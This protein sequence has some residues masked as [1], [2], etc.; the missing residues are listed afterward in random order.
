VERLVQ[1][2]LADLVVHRQYL[3]PD[4]SDMNSSESS[5]FA[6]FPNSTPGKQLLHR[7]KCSDC[8]FLL[9]EATGSFTHSTIG[10]RVH[11]EIF[12]LTRIREGKNKNG[13]WEYVVKPVIRR[14]GKSDLFKLN[15]L[16]LLT[17]AIGEFV[18]KYVAVS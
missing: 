9:F 8:T 18:E 11:R 14:W 12:P 5:S 7:V 13:E 3:D 16:A 1:I 6:S 2:E 17:T 10:S 4:F 15:L